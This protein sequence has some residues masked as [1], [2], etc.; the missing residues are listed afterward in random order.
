MT[1]DEQSKTTEDIR[2]KTR[3]EIDALEAELPTL[4]RALTPWILRVAIL[5]IAIFAV[6]RWQGTDMTWFLP[7]V[8]VYALVSLGLTYYA[9]VTQRKA[10]AKRRA[11]VEDNI[12]TAT[13]EDDT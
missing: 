7:L 4:K 1:D 6:M 3:A 5:A 2:A 10:F 13:D 11:A 8:A 12:S 9:Y